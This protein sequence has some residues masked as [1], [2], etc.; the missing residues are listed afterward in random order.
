MASC[1]HSLSRTTNSLLHRCAL[2]HAQQQIDPQ[3]VGGLPS[4]DARSGGTRNAVLVLT[5][6]ERES[7]EVIDQ[8]T[9]AARNARAQFAHERRQDSGLV[10][11]YP[12]RIRNPVRSTRNSK[13]KAAEERVLL[14]VTDKVR[15]SVCC[16]S[17]VQTNC[18]QK[19][20]GAHKRVLPKCT[21]NVQPEAQEG[22]QGSGSALETHSCDS[23]V[24]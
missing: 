19:R 24:R 5:A 9:S 15:S 8:S 22:R 12:L 1:V 13:R 17:R 11:T 20:K 6:T 23:V 14:K 21:D 10:R 18:N 4:S 3:F 16:C 7:F 2:M